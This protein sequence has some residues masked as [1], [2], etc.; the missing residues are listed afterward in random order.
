MRD[1]FVFYKS[2]QKSLNRLPDGESFKKVF[3]AMCDSIFNDKEFSEKDFTNEELIIIDLTIPLLQAAK[4]NYENG[5][6]GGRPAKINYEKAMGLKEKGLNNSQ[7]A[8]FFGVSK[9][10]I[11]IFF[12]ERKNEKTTEKTPKKS[13][14]NDNYNV[15]LND[16]EKDTVNVNEKEN[17]NKNNN[18]YI[19]ALSEIE[20]FCTSNNLIV[21]PQEFYDYYNEHGWE[22]VYNW[23]NLLKRWNSNQLTRQK[24]SASNDPY[25][26]LR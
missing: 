19:P 1:S 11:E 6:K 8:E 23:K 25:A 10:A 12:Q 21:N 20:S 17:I 9:R 13:N 15:N 26:V 24:Q 18:N 3:N 5:L 2:W 22:F 7:I 14:D 16:N 4:A